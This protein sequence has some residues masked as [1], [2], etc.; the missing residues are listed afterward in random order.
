M[1]DPEGSTRSPFHTHVLTIGRSSQDYAEVIDYHA[2]K[3]I[4]FMKGVTMVCSITGKYIHVC[5]GLMLYV[6]DRMERSSVIGQLH[7]GDDGKRSLWV[8]EIDPRHL[9]F[10]RK[11]FGR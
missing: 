6:T 11:C 7:L 4:D 8:A 1:P 5:M 10:C 2:A 9:L 3:V